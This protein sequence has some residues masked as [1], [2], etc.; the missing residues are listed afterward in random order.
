MDAAVRRW[1]VVG[2]RGSDV[3]VGL[4]ESGRLNAA[5]KLAPAPGNS[6]ISDYQ[7]SIAQYDPNGTPTLFDAGTT[8]SFAVAGWDNVPDWAVRVRAANGSGWG[9]WSAQVVVGGP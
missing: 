1:Y 9:P 4:V 8:T 5:G 2:A 6:P 3:A 7:V